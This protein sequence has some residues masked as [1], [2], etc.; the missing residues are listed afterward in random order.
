MIDRL[1]QEQST[2]RQTSARILT[3]DHL[4]TVAKRFEISFFCLKNLLINQP[5]IYKIVENWVLNSL[6]TN[7]K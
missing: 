6:C 5:K 7:I 3:H 4:G 2:H 1:K